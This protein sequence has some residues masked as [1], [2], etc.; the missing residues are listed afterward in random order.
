MNISRFVAFILFMFFILPA[1]F[2]QDENTL[3]RNNI[4]K[5]FDEIF[6]D[7]TLE[8]RGELDLFSSSRYEG[9]GHFKKEELISAL[10]SHND[11]L[12]T[13]EKL[14]GQKANEFWYSLALH[15]TD[16]KNDLALYYIGFLD[17]KY[18]NDTTLLN[19]NESSKFYGNLSLLQN[20]YT[21]SNTRDKIKYFFNKKNQ[22]NINP[23]TWETYFNTFNKDQKFTIELI[24]SFPVN[25][26]KLIFE[27]YLKDDEV[28]N[29]SLQKNACL[30]CQS[31]PLANDKEL[32]TYI[33]KNDK[34]NIK[35]HLNNKYGFKYRDN[36]SLWERI[37]FFIKNNLNY[38]IITFPIIVVLLLIYYGYKQSKKDAKEGEITPPIV[39]NDSEQFNK[40]LNLVRENSAAIASIIIRLDRVEKDIKEIKEVIAQ[41][42]TPTA[43]INQST[44]NSNSFKPFIA[45]IF[46]AYQFEN[47][48]LTKK[49]LFEEETPTLFFKIN[50]TSNSKAEFTLIQEQEK[51]AY[52]ANERKNF[53]NKEICRFEVEGPYPGNMISVQSLGKLKK[54]PS[55]DWEIDKPMRIKYITV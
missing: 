13:T 49:N 2:G 53:F 20:I 26:C 36:S 35:I 17:E 22:K 19:K 51:L 9:G 54:T 38:L 40:I 14:A 4:Q 25:D 50:T 27:R 5:I 44:S 10:K 7:Y 16:N 29:N 41:W 30:T 39:N 18:G 6:T 47:N 23:K 45:E 52:V 24:D 21:N 8:D 42:E 11:K 48:R 34:E 55:G 37:L 1:S 28:L 33:K 12:K 15:F 3:M 31:S 43:S 32:L 46:Y